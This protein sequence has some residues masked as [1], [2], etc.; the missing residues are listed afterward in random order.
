MRERYKHELP[1]WLRMLGA[2]RINHESVDFKWG[3]FAP[4]PG[5]ELVINRGTY[6][7]RRYA[8]N[9]A[10][11]WG[12][13]MV[14]LPFKT[15]LDEGCDMPRYGFA[16]HSQSLWLYKGGDYDGSQCQNQWIAWDLPFFSMVFD[17]HWIKDKQ[18]NWV[19][20]GRLTRGNQE[21]V[22]AYE[23]RKTLAATSTHPY[24]YVLKNGTVQE[25]IATCTVEKRQW[26][27]KWFPFLKL[28]RNVINVEFDEE[29]G[30]RT[31][32]WKGGV[33]GTSYEIL[34]HETVEQCLGRM[35]RDEKL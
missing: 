1:K 9:F 29:V 12:E 18:N 24:R 30:E 22:P 33:I 14:Y 35:E 6:F 5:L 34:P 4:R 21:G 7:D 2:W 20:M 28:E 15:N 10:L 11:G 26:H 13:F 23:F 3:Y 32:S 27:R 8:I 17:G 19:K 25:R 16:V 31:G